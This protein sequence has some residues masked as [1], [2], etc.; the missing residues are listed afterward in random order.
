[1]EQHDPT[2]RH[3]WRDF[4]LSENGPA[5][6]G[7]RLTALGVC[8]RVDNNTLE[9]WVS[10]AT[11]GAITDQSQ[12]TVETHLRALL[13]AGWLTSRTRLKGQDQVRGRGWRLRLLRLAVPAEHLAIF[14]ATRPAGLTA[15]SAGSPEEQARQAATV[16]RLPAKNDTTTGNSCYQ[17]RSDISLRDLSKSAKA[18]RD[19][20]PTPR[21]ADDPEARQ[22]VKTRAESIG[23][24]DQEPG[25]SFARY[26]ACVMVAFY[27]AK[28]AAQ[29]RP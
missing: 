3:D 5:G 4:V 20:N 29:E 16:A 27:E 11:I 9:T 19:R 23:Y 15:N 21:A 28:A 13:A 26:S 22:R 25:E 24:R 2:W 8:K 14:A 18:L 1:M 7:A 12:R 6:G 17:S 10:A